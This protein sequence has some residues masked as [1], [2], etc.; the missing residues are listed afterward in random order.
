MTEVDPP[1]AEYREA[2]AAFHAA[3]ARLQRSRGVLVALRGCETPWSDEDAEQMGFEIT[4]GTGLAILNDIP[5][6][7]TGSRWFNWKQT[8]ALSRWLATKVEQC[9][10]IA[11]T[12]ATA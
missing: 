11:S 4:P 5:S 8:V 12:R 9:R 1:E 3:V 2:L 7:Y 10:L 6:L